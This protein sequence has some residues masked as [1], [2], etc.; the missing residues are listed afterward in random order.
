MT[1]VNQCMLSIVKR[2]LIKA[3]VHSTITSIERCQPSG[4]NR[5]YKVATGTGIFLAKQYFTHPGDA[6]DRLG[7]EYRFLIY[8]KKNAPFYVPTPLAFEADT[9]CALYEFIEGRSY[10]V[11]EI[12]WNVVQSATNFFLLLNQK[13]SKAQ[14]NNFPIASEACFSINDHLKTI[15]SRISQ[16]FNC[17]Q[18]TNQSSKIFNTLMDQIRETWEEVDAAV[19]RD[20]NGFGLN[21]DY[22]LAESERCISPSDFG[23]HNAIRH[24]DGSTKFIDF[25]YA[26]WDDP[27]KMAADFFAQLAIPIPEYLFNYFLDEIVKPFDN[28]AE[29][30]V[31]SLLLRPAYQIKWCCIALNIFLPVNLSRRRF[32]SDFLKDTERKNQQLVKATKIIE[33]IRISSNGVH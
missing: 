13:D 4:N 21:I 26:G 11:T 18:P 32:A 7:T 14:L 1:S 10:Q 22:V 19:R 17:K 6:R 29:L 28:I 24:A 5:T 2:L 23:F 12:N 33:S 3:N 27:A 15:K 25:E 30:R 9:G 16:L 31:R 20:A 8:A